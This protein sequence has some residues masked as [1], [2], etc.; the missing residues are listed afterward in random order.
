MKLPIPVDLATAFPSV[1]EHLG[2]P[3]I[4]QSPFAEWSLQPGI[5]TTWVNGK[6]A[7]HAADIELLVIPLD[8]RVLHSLPDS[9]CLHRR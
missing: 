1:L 6:H 8:E 9:R 5:E 7:A 4:L 2:L 3:R